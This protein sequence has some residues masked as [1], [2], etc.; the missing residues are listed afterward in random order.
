MSLS[1]CSC[2]GSSLDMDLLLCMAWYNVHGL[3]RHERIESGCQ[4]ALVGRTDRSGLFFLP[5]LLSSLLSSFL[6]LSSILTIELQI[7]QPT[8]DYFDCFDNFDLITAYKDSL[9]YKVRTTYLVTRFDTLRQSQNPR[10][11]PI[12]EGTATFFDGDHFIYISHM[13]ELFFLSCRRCIKFLFDKSG[14]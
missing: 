9:Q 1:V 6:T 4:P 8:S 14:V 11:Y 5:W 3:L 13:A 2:K 10:Q 7:Q 12:T